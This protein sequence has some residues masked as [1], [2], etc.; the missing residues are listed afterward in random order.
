MITPLCHYDYGWNEVCMADQSTLGACNASF[1]SKGTDEVVVLCPKG[2]FS[3][4]GI[5]H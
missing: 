5:R 2:A 3:D 4:F 1:V